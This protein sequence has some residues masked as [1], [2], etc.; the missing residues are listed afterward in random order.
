M[1]RFTFFI[2]EDTEA[3]TATDFNKVSRGILLVESGGDL[4][5]EPSNLSRT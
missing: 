5:A 4:K 1:A 2:R 3:P